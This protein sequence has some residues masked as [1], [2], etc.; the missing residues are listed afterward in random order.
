MAEH[1]YYYHSEWRDLTF[2]CSGCDWSGRTTQMDT[3]VLDQTIDYS[4]S[5]C[6]KTLVI[7]SLPNSRDL[8]A[9][10]VAGNSEAI[11]DLAKKDD[12]P[13]VLSLH[14]LRTQ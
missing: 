13:H 6:E 11:T 4:C 12:M 1:F 7:V 3:K 9:A 2:C 10:V 5:Q 8:K 14:L